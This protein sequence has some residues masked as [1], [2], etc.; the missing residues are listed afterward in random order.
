MKATIEERGNGFPGNG[1]YVVEA[2]ELYRIVDI[3]SGRIETRGCGAPNVMP[4]VTVEPA[5]WQDISD[6][7]EPY[8]TCVVAGD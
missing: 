5:D 2:G 1:E 3:G 7:Q 6:D 4:D 8:A